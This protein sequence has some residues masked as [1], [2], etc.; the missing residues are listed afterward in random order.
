MEIH[1]LRYFLAVAQ[2]GSFTGAAELCHVS[3]P[4]LSAQIAKL[5]TELGGQLLERSRHGARLSNRGEEFR[6]HAAEALRQLESG[7]QRLEELSGLT[8]G[9][10]TLGCLPTTG[11]YLLPQI[12][13]SFLDAHPHV[14][15]NLQEA[16]S[17]QLAKA[18]REFE[19]DLAIIDEAG[20]G[21]GISAEELFR[22]P[23][24]LAVPPDHRFAGKDSVPLSALKA[25]QFVLMKSGRG[26]RRIVTDALSAAGI[27]PQIVYESDEIETVQRFVEAGLGITIVPRMVRKEQGPVYVRISPP[28]PSRTLLLARRQSGTLSAAGEAMRKIALSVLGKKDNPRRANDSAG[29]RGL[30]HRA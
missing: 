23:L 30:K 21:P 29:V 17:P 3:Q 15:V 25:E 28:T 22:E 4:S 14:R 10:V 8:R 11:A 1:Q 12:L 6:P 5:E 16:S 27:E 2:S 19:I 18:L 9:A 26:Y 13:R 24:I 20:L 7:R